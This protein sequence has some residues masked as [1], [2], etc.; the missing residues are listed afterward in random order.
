MLNAGIARGTNPSRALI[1]KGRI[2]SRLRSVGVARDFYIR[3]LQGT[4]ADTGEKC[5][6]EA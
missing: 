6:L 5:C 1:L 4:A 2:N 3:P